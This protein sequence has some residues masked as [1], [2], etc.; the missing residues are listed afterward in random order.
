MAVVTLGYNRL[1]FFFFNETL[2]CMKTKEVTGAV[3]TPA[4]RNV[5][6]VKSGVLQPHV[7]RRECLK[8]K[9]KKRS[10]VYQDDKK[11]LLL[12]KCSHRQI[13]RHDPRHKKKNP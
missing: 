6:V 12:R 2:K 11:T 5:S 3:F 13:H 10:L 7:G 9:E 4:P 1:K 8:K